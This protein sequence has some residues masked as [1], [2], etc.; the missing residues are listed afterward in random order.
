MDKPFTQKDLKGLGWT[1]LEGS[2]EGVMT[3]GQL[4]YW[5]EYKHQYTPGAFEIVSS[6]SR[7]NW[8][9]T[10]QTLAQLLNLMALMEDIEKWVQQN[11]QSDATE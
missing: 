7:L 4:E 3:N 10:P 11:D 1:R 6:Q 9:L 8:R 2:P 5:P